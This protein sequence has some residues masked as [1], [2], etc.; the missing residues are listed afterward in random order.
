MNNIVAQVIVPFEHLGCQ[1]GISSENGRI[2]HK[3]GHFVSEGARRAVK[4]KAATTGVGV[5]GPVKSA[6][7]S[8]MVAV[9]WLA[10]SFPEPLSR[11]S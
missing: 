4:Q 11:C 8:A 2:T 1:E 7:V 10:E 6:S 3:F 9:V 5:C